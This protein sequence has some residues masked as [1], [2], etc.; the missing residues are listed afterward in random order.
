MRVKVLGPNLVDQSH[1]QINVH[2]EGCGDLKRS[3]NRNVED[4]AFFDVASRRE[5]VELEYPRDQFEWSDGPD[6][7]W[8]WGDVW[9][10]PCL[11]TLP[12][13]AA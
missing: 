13:E 1:G 12:R 4:W 6:D 8:Y 5:V 2:A 11:K 3:K 7:E 10:A 9:F